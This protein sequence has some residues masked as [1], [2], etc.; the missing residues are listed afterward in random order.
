MPAAAFRT[1]GERN[2]CVLTQLQQICCVVVVICVFMAGG[3]C[4]N[5]YFVWEEYYDRGGV[6]LSTVYARLVLN[7]SLFFAS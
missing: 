4:T 1:Y 3:H 6:P 7:L 5:H 2:I